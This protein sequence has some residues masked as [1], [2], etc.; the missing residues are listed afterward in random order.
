MIN[1]TTINEITI[2]AKLIENKKRKIRI[3]LEMDR[4][5]MDKFI[6]Q[7]GKQPRGIFSQV[8]EIKEVN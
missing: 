5:D 4:Y 6:L 8:V 3:I 2:K 7:S 1:K